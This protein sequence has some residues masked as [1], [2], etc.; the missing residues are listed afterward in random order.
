MPLTIVRARVV[1]GL[2]M[3]DDKGKDDKIIA[4]AVDDPAYNHYDAL[5]QLPPHV[6]VE[7]DRFFRDYKVLEGKATVV[8]QPYGRARAL[9]VVRAARAGYDALHP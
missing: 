4:V 8:D 2:E 7:L 6:T 5:D 3:T 9:D 1:G